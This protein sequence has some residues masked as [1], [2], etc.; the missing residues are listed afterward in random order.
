MKTILLSALTVSLL[1][2]CSTTPRW[3]KRFGEAVRESTQAQALPPTVPETVLPALDGTS[4]EHAMQRYHDASKQPPPV[5]N[6]F[7][8]GVGTGQ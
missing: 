2:A 5:T 6:V 4:A 3:D 7:N 8:I 1:A